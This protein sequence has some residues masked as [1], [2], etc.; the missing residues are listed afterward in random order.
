MNFCRNSLRRNSSN[1]NTDKSDF[2]SYYPSQELM[3]EKSI[4]LG[5]EFHIKV[6]S[7][8]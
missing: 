4:F 2:F 5:A 7:G 3:P 8:P 6:M 1:G